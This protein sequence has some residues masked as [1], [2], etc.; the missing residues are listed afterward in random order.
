MILHYSPS[1]SYANT[2]DNLSWTISQFADSRQNQKNISADN[3]LHRSTAFPSL[4]ADINKVNGQLLSRLRTA[5]ARTAVQNIGRQILHSIRLAHLR[6]Y[7]KEIIFIGR[8]R[9]SLHRSKTLVKKL[10][11]IAC[12][13][14]PLINYAQSNDSLTQDK[15]SINTGIVVSGGINVI[16]YYS[17]AFIN[18]LFNKTGSSAPFIIG[19]GY[20]ITNGST[21]PSKF[22]YSKSS[23]F[24]NISIGLELNRNNDRKIKINHIIETNFIKLSGKYSYDVFYT[25]STGGGPPSW[26][27]VRDTAHIQYTQTIL[28]LNYKFEPTYKN[29]FLSLGIISSLNLIKIEE[30]KQEQLDHWFYD[31]ANSQ[32]VHAY[33]IK[34]NIDT[35]RNSYFINGSMQIGAGGYLKLKK[36]VL[37]PSFYFT[38]YFKKNYNI[39]NISLGILFCKKK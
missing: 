3:S 15:H 31:E 1:D 27:D 34:N 23:S 2:R 37:K 21:I 29:I 5:Y 28:S 26:T 14:M 8:K 17:D 36:I 22:N 16:Q 9:A 12:I 13:L 11:L 7:C 39:Y 32:T 33:T 19:T 6:P 10:F 30:Q 35:T 20:P 18:Y 25:Q 4:T 24:P 38:P